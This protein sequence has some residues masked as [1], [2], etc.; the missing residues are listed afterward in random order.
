MKSFLRDVLLT[1][2][3][4]V[5]IYLGVRLTIQTFI[6]NGTSMLPDSQNGEWVIVNKLAY[7][8]QTP[9]RGDIVIFEA[10][11]PRHNG[12]NLIKRVIGLPGE[13]VE[14]KDA[15][16]FIHKQNGEVMPLKEP[17][18]EEP[19]RAGYRSNI[20]PPGEYVVMGDNRN[21]SGDSREG[22]TLP[23]KNIIGKAWIV[24]WPLKAWAA[25]PNYSFSAN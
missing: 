13:W 10:V 16:V 9:Q 8:F 24:I 11:P 1:V 6:V 21:V 23:T 19:M 15:T 20:I 22:W 14:I 17:Y 7:K 2:V 3:L 4:A 12:E 5:L 25:A 18:L